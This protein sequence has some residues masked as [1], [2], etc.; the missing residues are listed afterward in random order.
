MIIVGRFMIYINN[1]V[2]RLKYHESKNNKDFCMSIR[3]AKDLHGDITKLLASLYEL[4]DIKH[5]PP[6]DEVISGG[7]F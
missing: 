2:D 4:H 3:D 1:F 5:E 7:S 6:S